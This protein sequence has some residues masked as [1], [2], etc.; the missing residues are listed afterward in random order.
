MSH[1]GPSDRH[2]LVNRNE[3]SELE[4]PFGGAWREHRRYVL[5]VALRMLGDIGEAEDV[6]Q[7]AFIRLAR[8]NLDEIDDVR[9]WLLTVVS[10]LCLDQLRSARRQRQEPLDDGSDGLA[11][12]DRVAST[13]AVDPADRVTL[14]DSVRLALTVMLERLTPAERTAFVLHDVFQLSFDDIAGIVGRSV[15]ACRQLASRARR[16]LG[17]DG[18]PARFVVATT[19]QHDAAA[20]FISAASTGDLDGLLAVLDP[21]VDG[22]VDLG[23]GKRGGG[24]AGPAGGPGWVARVARGV[25]RYIGPRAGVTLV[26]LPTGPRPSILALRDDHA[27]AV[28][29]LTVRDRRI[30]HID[31]LADPARLASITAALGG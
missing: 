16:H 23:G 15:E 3:P 6:V 31:V 18:D 17:S 13:T 25:L 8:T 29:T 2:L 4:T 1:R 22:D 5:D 19:D 12:L 14:D 26:S 20:A 24:L 21:D 30:E 27:V 10:R 7:E 11:P 28:L 9:A